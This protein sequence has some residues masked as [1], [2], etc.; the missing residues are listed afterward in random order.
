M[1]NFKLRSLGLVVHSALTRYMASAGL[2]SFALASELDAPAL[3]KL[4]ESQRGWYTEKDGKFTLDLTKVEVEDTSGLKTAL[5]KERQAAKDATAAAKTAVQEAMKA[6]EGIDPVKTRALLAKFNDEE[7][8]ALIAAG[9]VDEVI[10]KRMAKRDADMQKQLDAAKA[11]TEAAKGVAGT[12]KGRVL[13]NHIRAAAAKAGLHPFAV[14]DALLRA[15]ALFSLDDKGEAVQLGTDGT[16]VLGKD[17]KTAFT[18]TEWLESMK[19]AAPHWFPAGGSGGGAGGSG[20]AG[21]GG[22][23]IKREAFDAMT[24]AEKSRVVKTHAIVD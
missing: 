17:G 12:F 24:P 11:E 13:D 18:P 2:M 23:T 1:K 5:A 20:G 8:A 4:P 14:E 10:A 7:E 21:A 15:R 19:E 22:K 16:P 9:K 6:Y 3:G